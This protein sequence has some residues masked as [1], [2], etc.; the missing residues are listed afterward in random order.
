VPPK[1]AGYHKRTQ[2]GETF[3]YEQHKIKAKEK[4]KIEAVYQIPDRG[5]EAADDDDDE[6]A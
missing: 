1:L 5:K 6:G 2:S 3:R 4:S